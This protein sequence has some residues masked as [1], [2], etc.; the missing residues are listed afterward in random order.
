MEN[1]TNKGATM[2][3]LNVGDSV[4]RKGIPEHVGTLVAVNKQVHSVIVEW[5]HGIS[6]DRSNRLVKV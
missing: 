1:K 3:T 2:T 6:V 5:K 4:S